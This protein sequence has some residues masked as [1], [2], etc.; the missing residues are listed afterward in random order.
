MGCKENPPFNWPSE[1]Y[2]G[3]V[4]TWVVQHF[5]SDVTLYDFQ[6]IKKCIQC[7]RSI[8]LKNKKLDSNVEVNQL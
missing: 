2:N 7:T 5:Y 4:Q 3:C 1:R 6:C 8:H